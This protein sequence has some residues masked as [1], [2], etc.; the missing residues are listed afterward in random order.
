MNLY[1]DGRTGKERR[2]GDLAFPQAGECRTSPERRNPGMSV[3]KMADYH[4]VL[5]DG[6]WGAS[7]DDST[8]E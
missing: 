4:R 8:S 1:L 6:Y 5:A 3:E 2:E 7:E